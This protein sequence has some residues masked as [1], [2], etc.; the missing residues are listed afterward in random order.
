MGIA[1]LPFNGHATTLQTWCGLSA[2]DGRYQTKDLIEQIQT[3]DSFTEVKNRIISCD[4]LCI[5]E[6][7]MV[8]RKL[9][10]TVEEVQFLH[11]KIRWPRKYV[12]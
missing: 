3:D 11:P 6:T 7:S 8:S 2:R 9:F 10:Q 12:V 4:A 5:D 1:T